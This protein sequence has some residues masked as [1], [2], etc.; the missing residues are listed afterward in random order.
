M[1]NAIALL[2]VMLGAGALLLI[3]APDLLAQIP[4]IGD[5][6]KFSI[7]PVTG[8]TPAMVT[9]PFIPPPNGH[10]GVD[11]GVP[12]GTPLL[13]VAPGTVAQVQRDPNNDSGMFVIV[14]GRLPFS[15]TIA[16]GYAH[17]SRIDVTVGQDLDAGDVVGLSG[18][19][20]LTS[21]GGAA[22]LNRT[23]GHG[24]HLHFTAL[25]VAR[26]F[27]SVDPAAFLPQDLGAGG[28]V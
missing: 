28:N 9:Q 24:A 22:I 2:V 1:P 5:A 8:F 23:D 14:K 12:I 26:G 6:V 19:T 17:M 3:G 10:N 27:Q 11:F 4:F 15:P 25:D 20:G 13:C 18:N 16:W 7:M 21:S